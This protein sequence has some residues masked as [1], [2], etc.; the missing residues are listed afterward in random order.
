LKTLK[1]ALPVIVVG[2]FGATLI[3]APAFA[4]PPGCGHDICM[5][6]GSNYTAG[7]LGQNNADTNLSGNRFDTTASA[8]DAI[9]SISTHTGSAT[10][11]CTDSWWSGNCFKAHGNA[12]MPTLSATFNNKLSSWKYD[13]L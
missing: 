4:A 3:G 13:R 8:N 12:S 5:Y 9:T 11:F 2:T 1:T 10:E 6:D 7:V